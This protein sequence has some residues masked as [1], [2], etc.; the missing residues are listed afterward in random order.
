[1]DSY[2]QMMPAPNE[3]LLD[4]KPDTNDIDARLFENIVDEELF[5]DELLGSEDMDAV[6][7]RNSAMSINR[8]ANLEA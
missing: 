3:A 5:Y 1:M 6:S 4:F 7:S 2:R 8:P